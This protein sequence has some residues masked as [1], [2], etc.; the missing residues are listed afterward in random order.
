MPIASERSY[1][2]SL[3]LAFHDEIEFVIRTL[4]LASYSSTPDGR[5]KKDK[6]RSFGSQALSF[7]YSRYAVDRSSDCFRN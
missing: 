4:K 6:K 3:N 2:Y 5:Y 1:D 7:N